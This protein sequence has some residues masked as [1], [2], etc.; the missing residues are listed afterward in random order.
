[1]KALEIKDL[2]KDFGKNKVLSGISFEVEEGEIFGFLGPNGAGKTTTMRIILGLLKPDEGEA[3]VMGHSLDTDD[4]ARAGVG[5]LFENN[6]LYDKLTA[7]ENLDY[8]ADLYGIEDKE[9][10]I[11]YLLQLTGISGRK[12]DQVG[13]FSTG[14]KR[15]LG[16]VRAILHRPDVLFLD[17]PTAS[18]DPE[19][20]KMVR[21]L[22]LHLSEAESMTV[23]FNSHNLSEVQ[24]ICSRVA[25]LHN[26]RIK[27]LDTVENLQ[28]DAGRTGVRITLCDLADTAKAESVLKDAGDVSEFVFDGNSVS[29]TLATGSASSLIEKLVM[30]GI[31]IEEAVSEKHSL[32]EIYM[33]TIK[34]RGGE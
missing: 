33:E 14:M 31:S 4:A 29:V 20:Q 2:K 17:E 23:F 27:A 11:S 30:S 12:D 25:I 26:G 5:V 15:K 22:I 6:G 10:R 19:A 24:K 1:M 18:L 8:Y 32:E 9:E 13:T 7:L 16:I 34:E 28:S 3:L 21:D